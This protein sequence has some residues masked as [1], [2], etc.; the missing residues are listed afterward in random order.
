MS[1]AARKLTLVFAALSLGAGGLIASEAWVL[2]GYPD[3][4]HGNKVPTACGGVTE[5]VV[6]GRVYT[7]QE[8]LQM[9]AAAMVKHATPVLPCL[10]DDFPADGAPYLKVMLD[11]AYNIGTGAFR[12]SS[13]CRKMQAGDYA[14]ACASILKWDRAGGK[15][16]NIRANNCYGVVVRRREAYA[17]CMRALP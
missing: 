17:Q 12:G 15:D 8:C 5:G 3:P 14:G 11:T 7:E 2:K 13:M 1:P 16:C 4:V 10:R 9:Q 6:I